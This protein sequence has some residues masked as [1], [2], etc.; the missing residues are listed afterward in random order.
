MGV[1]VVKSGG[2]EVVPA[3]FEGKPEQNGKVDQGKGDKVSI[4]FGS[5]GE[6]P[7]KGEEKNNN[8]LVSDVPK[9]AAEE[10]PAT[11]QIH[12]FYFVKYRPYDDPK[13]KAKLDLAD[14]E[15]EKLSNARGGVFDK[16]KAKRVSFGTLEDILG[17]PNFSC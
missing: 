4:K 7:K 5:H 13:I 9:D 2:F 6:Q 8:V 14:K 1:E 16:L 12:A 11:K 17:F 3:P 15:L 10:W